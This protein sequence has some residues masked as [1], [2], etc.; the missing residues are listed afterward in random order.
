MVVDVVLWHW[1][2]VVAETERTVEP[3][4]EGFGQEIQR[5]AA[6]FYA[7]NILFVSTRA[8]RLH[9]AF[10]VLREM[11]D[12]V[13]LL[14][15]VVKTVIMVYQPCCTI[16]GNSAEAYGLRMT[17][18]VLTYRD[19]LRQQARCTECDADLAAG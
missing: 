16:G 1:F 17:G 2:T 7:D 12:W 5:M 6:Y 4:T 10:D 18:W 19:R 11:F 13:G 8:T 9:R 3:G 15:R 14:T